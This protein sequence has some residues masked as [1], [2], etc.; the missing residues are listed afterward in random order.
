MMIRLVIRAH[1]VCESSV[2]VDV[3][4]IL[5]MMNGCCMKVL[6]KYLYMHNIILFIMEYYYYYVL[7]LHLCVISSMLSETTCAR[8]QLVLLIEEW[9]RYLSMKFKTN[10]AC[11]IPPSQT[12]HNCLT[13]PINRC[14]TSQN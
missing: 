12:F 2:Q 1:E 10:N 6:Y 3:V 13:I 11:L 9:L 7:I 8:H 5:F 4:C 14:R